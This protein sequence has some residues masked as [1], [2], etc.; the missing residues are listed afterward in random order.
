M[1]RW[2]VDNMNPCFVSTGGGGVYAVS[3]FINAGGMAQCPTNVGPT[4]VPEPG[5]NWSTNRLT[6][7]C[8]GSFR[9]CYTIKAGDREN[10]MDSDCIIAESC[11]DTYYGTAGAVQELPEL[12]PWT[13]T[14]TACIQAFQSTGGYGEMSVL[15]VS[16]E[17]DAIDDGSGERRVFNRVGYCPA[18]CNT[19]PDLPECMNCRMGGSGGF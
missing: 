5:K 18:R 2:E 15:G 3:T 8:A 1:G 17:C 14:Q 11:V 10:P 13:S 12:P 4:P 7:D 6:V 9:L 16:I 19:M